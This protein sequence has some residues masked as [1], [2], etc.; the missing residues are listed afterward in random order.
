VYGV[1][2]AGA[3]LSKSGAA[4]AAGY[5]TPRVGAWR[6]MYRVGAWR[7]KSSRSRSVAQQ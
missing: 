1:A 3:W 5:M 2:A 6:I 7:S 4:V